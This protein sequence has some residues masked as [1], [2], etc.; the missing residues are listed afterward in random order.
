MSRLRASLEEGSVK[1][2]AARAKKK[3]VAARQKPVRAKKK[4][5]A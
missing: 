2:G 3:S 1:K 4:K 5:T